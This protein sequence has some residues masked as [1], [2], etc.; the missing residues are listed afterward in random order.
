M[1]IFFTGLLLLF[2]TT[3]IAHEV[4]PAYLR[5][6]DISE[7]NGANH[8][9]FLWRVPSG[10]EVPLT[11]FVVLPE[12]CPAVGEPSAWTD[13]GVR[14]E[15]W[16][17]RCDGGLTGKTVT[18]GDLTAS[19]TDVLVRYERL[20]GTAQVVRL[21]PTSPDFVATESE[22]ITE[23][24]A[25]YAFLG[26]EHIL[27]GIDHLLFV[28][29]LLLIVDGWRKLVATVTSFTVAHSITLGAATLGLVKVPQAPVEAVIAL[30][31][32]FV[33]ME[34]VHWRQG[35]PGLTRQW[36]WIVA[37]AFGL[38]HGFGFAGA[39]SS[40]GLPDHAIPVAL[41]FFNLGVE[42]GQLLFIVAAL[43]V[44][45]LLQKIRWPEWAWRI[46][47]YAI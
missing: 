6:A 21:T 5:I 13:G 15:K 31:I 8:Y 34:I 18:I 12:E 27:L 38:L 32:L 4:R 10:G 29:A 3:A 17:S 45:Q 47:V 23:V 46:P 42:A 25:T 9:E 16:I 30:S 36:P 7:S 35:R 24:A 26:V 44:W 1:R 2:S 14:I 43:V 22:S 28:L 33:A 11:I 20:D 40:I 19:V 37:F 39:L 41:L